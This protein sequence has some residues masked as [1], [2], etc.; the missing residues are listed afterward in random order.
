MTTEGGLRQCLTDLTRAD[1]SGDYQKALLAA[2]RLIRRYPKEHYAF[3]CKLVCLIHLS[4]YD[5][6]LTLLRKT[7]PM[8]AYRVFTYILYRLERNDDALEAL[9]ACDKSDHRAQELRAQ[10]YYRLDRFQE[11]LEIFRDLLRNHSDSYDDERKANYLAVVAQLEAMGIKQQSSTDSETFEQ[12]YNSACQLI[13]AG[14]Y[15]LALKNLDKSIETLSEEG[16]D[17]EEVEDE[18]AVLCVQLDY[19]CH[20]YKGVQQS[21]ADARRKLKSA[22]QLDQK[23]LS[24]RQRRIL[25]LNN[26]LVLLHSNQREPCRRAL[27]DLIKAFGVTRDTRLIEAALCF[28]LNEFEKAIKVRFNVEALQHKSIVTVSVLFISFPGK[29]EDAITALKELPPNVRL[30]SAVVSLAVSLLISLERKEDALKVG[31]KEQAVQ[32]ILQYPCVGSCNKTSIVKVFPVT[33]DESINVDN[34]E[35]SDWILYGEKY[36][37]KKEAK[38]EEIVTRKLKNRKRK[39]KIRLPKNYDPNVPPDP[40]RWLP[41]QER[42]A[43]KKRQKK[44]RDRDIG[45]GTQGSASTNPNVEYVSA[46]PSS[47]RP[48]TITMPEGPRQMRPKQQPKKKKKPSKF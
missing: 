33:V 13:E 6:A 3:K 8:L 41:K 43:Y 5:D 27:D 28:R 26:A 32:G 31:F 20:S 19:N 44:N 14:N 1:T 46:S 45:R 38:S 16:L 23:K 11:A 12:L 24:T 21:I 42:A 7:P 22:L 10:L 39:R 36:K 15:E 30:Q 34:L 48:M 37:Q 4:M 18:L 47:P 29:L 40:E 9:I 17:E 2:N 35:E 25:M